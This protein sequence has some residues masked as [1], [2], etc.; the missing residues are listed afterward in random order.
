[1]TKTRSYWTLYRRLLLLGTLPALGMFLVL[2]VFFTSARIDDARQEIYN[3]GKIVADNLAPAA[4]YP[5][6]TGNEQALD[7]LL[8]STLER[9]N[10]AWIRVEDVLGDEVGYVKNQGLI[11][12]KAP[13]K[14][15]TTEIVQQPV[16]LDQNEEL[17]WFEPDYGLGPSGAVKVGTV[18]VGV[19]ERPLTRERQEIIWTSIGLGTALL[20]LTLIFINRFAHRLSAP[21]SRLSERVQRISR[22]EYQIETEPMTVA[23]ELQTLQDAIVTMASDLEDADV[24]RQQTIGQIEQARNNAERAS[25][26]KSEFLAMMSHELRTPLNGI[27][28][29]LDLMAETPLK[30]EQKD[31]LL[32]ARQSTEDLLTIITDLLDFSRIEQGKLAIQHQKF[33][34]RD[35]LENCSASFRHETQERHLE[36]DIL[37]RGDWE[38]PLEVYGDPAR[39]RQVLAH[40]LGNAIKFTDEGFVKLSLHWE[41]VSEREGLLT[42]EIQD[43]GAGIPNERIRE[44][45]NTFEQLDRS[46]SRAYG[47]TGLGLPLAQRLVELMGGHIAVDTAVACGSTFRFVIP[48]EIAPRDD[49]QLHDYRPA[50]ADAN[51]ASGNARYALVVEDNPVN[52][53]VARRLLETFG[54]IVECA[55]NGE[56]A[57]NLIRRKGAESNRAPYDAILMDCQMPVMDG[58]EATRRIREWER[59]RAHGPMPIIALTADVLDGTEASCQEAGMNDYIPKPVRKQVIRETLQ[60]WL[61]V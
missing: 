48:L 12:S 19:S 13:I 14:T 47:G 42:C 38:E 46:N 23:S 17:S 24:K 37:F 44:M 2:L 6:V 25:R 43:S 31:Y 55:D 5:V 59:Q 22:G 10:L 51:E 8:Q 36:Y 7:S 3:N 60:R 56:Q 18:E 32:T 15:F 41:E 27:L 9:S 52:Q 1:M 26:T 34:V 30:Q 35:L 58:W 53:R 54:F 21:I 40:L 16:E 20:G 33:N 50:K 61:H 11:D 45:F 29:M 4:E 39:L 57:I 28:G 49:H